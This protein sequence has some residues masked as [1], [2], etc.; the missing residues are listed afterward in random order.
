MA[1]T[2]PVVLVDYFKD[3]APGQ[4]I[5]ISSDSRNPESFS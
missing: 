4:T 5:R 2:C 3:V 1:R